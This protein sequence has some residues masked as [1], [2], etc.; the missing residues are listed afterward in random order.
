MGNNGISDAFRGT[1]QF[2]EGVF[3][4]ELV[5]VRG[6]GVN[7]AT[8]TTVQGNRNASIVLSRTADIADAVGIGQRIGFCYDNLLGR[9]GTVPTGHVDV[10][11]TRGQVGEGTGYLWPGNAIGSIQ[12]GTIVSV[13]KLKAVIAQSAFGIGKNDGR[14]F[15]GTVDDGR[16]LVYG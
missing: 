13:I 6:D 3:R 8:G 14:I 10:V 15:T 12:R 11:R 9:S 16:A 4:I 7:I 5:E 1:G 2:V